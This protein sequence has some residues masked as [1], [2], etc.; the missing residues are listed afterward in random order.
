[1][2]SSNLEVGLRDAQACAAFGL[3]EFLEFRVEYRSER[4]QHFW[5]DHE[6]LG[7]ILAVITA[8]AH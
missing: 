6:H 2:L 8:C 4:K 1:M 3:A 7:R 5:W